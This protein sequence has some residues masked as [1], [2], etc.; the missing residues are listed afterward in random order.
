MTIE[1]KEKKV[2]LSKATYESLNNLS[3]H[4]NESGSVI[5]NH[6]NIVADLIAKAEKREC[7]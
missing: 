1:Y 7:K 3:A 2:G 6:K 5:R 4:R